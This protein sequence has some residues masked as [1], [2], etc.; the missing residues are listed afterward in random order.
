M[1]RR[2]SYVAFVSPALMV[3]V[4]IMVLPLIFSFVVGFTQW[5]GVGDM[6]FIGFRNYVQALKNPVFQHSMMNTFWIVVGVGLA[7]FSLSFFLTIFLQNMWGKKTVRYIIFFPTLIPGIVISI[8]WGFLFNPDG[9][10]NKF[11]EAIGVTNPPPWLSQ[12]HIF[13]VILLGMVWLNI[14]VYTVILLAAA[15]RIPVE[16]YEVADLAGVSLVQRFWYVTLPLMWEM[17]S[18]TTILWCVS[19]LKTFEF[20]LTFSSTIGNLPNAHI[21]NIAIYSYAEAFP[22]IG[23]ARFGSACAVGVIMVILAMALTVLARRVLRR[24]NVEY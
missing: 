9:L 13:P 5:A 22:S 10:I 19:A 7:V 18:V 8:L 15:D 11:L 16:L 24:E 1:T 3:F 23:V 17:V 4:V 20:L 14:G 6:K 21:W 12:A 2:R